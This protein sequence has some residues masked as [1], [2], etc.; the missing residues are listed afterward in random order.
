MRSWWP[1]FM[2]RKNLAKE[3]WLLHLDD[4]ALTR[5]GIE[6]LSKE[7]IDKESYI[8]KTILWQYQLILRLFIFYIII[9]RHAMHE[10]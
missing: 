3:M 9:L 2:L 7:E 6:N 4:I 1:T 10:G 8:L 5:E